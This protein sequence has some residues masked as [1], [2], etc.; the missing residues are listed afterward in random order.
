M[1]CDPMG[2][3]GAIPLM[4]EAKFDLGEGIGSRD[5][6]KWLDGQGKCVVCCRYVV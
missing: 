6:V 1:L 4:D 2:G 5:L 3:S